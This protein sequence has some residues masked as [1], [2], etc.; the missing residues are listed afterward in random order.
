MPGDVGRRQGEDLLHCG[1]FN[2]PDEFAVARAERKSH[3][4]AD[5]EPVAVSDAGAKRAAQQVT[6]TLADAVADRKPV[7]VSN[8]SALF[9]AEQIAHSTA[10]EESF[11]LPNAFAH[12]EPDTVPHHLT[13]RE[14]HT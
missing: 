12:G 7:A 9:G 11:S 6:D 3:K 10:V 2:E 13:D 4:I 5:R 14:P 8:A 1:A